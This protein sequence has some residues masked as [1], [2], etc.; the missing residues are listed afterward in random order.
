MHISD[1]LG[2]CFLCDRKICSPIR[3]LA[4]AFWSSWP[5]QGFPEQLT[6]TCILCSREI[7]TWCRFK[8]LE[9]N[10][11]WGNARNE[12]A[13]DERQANVPSIH[14]YPILSIPWHMSLSHQGG[15]SHR[16]PLALLRVNQAGEPLILALSSAELDHSYLTACRRIHDVYRNW[17]GWLILFDLA[18]ERQI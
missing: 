7:Q 1:H 17:K 10:T 5:L 8:R 4:W 9:R 14:I 13:N 18:R 16:R 2:S 3:S 6:M 12:M 11:D 15:D